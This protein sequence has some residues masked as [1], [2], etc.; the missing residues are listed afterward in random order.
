MPV[1]LHF[2]IGIGRN[3]E[4]E[5]HVQARQI[6]R[7]RGPDRVFYRPLPPTYKLDV[8][9]FGHAGGTIHRNIDPGAFI[10]PHVGLHGEV[11]ERAVQLRFAR[12]HGLPV[13][14]VAVFVFRRGVQDFEPSQV[15]VEIQLEILEI[16]VIHAAPNHGGVTVGV[17]QN[18]ATGDD[19]VFAEVDFVVE[20]QVRF[21]VIEGSAALHHIDGTTQQRCFWRTPNID[22]TQQRTPK[23]RENIFGERGYQ[24]QFGVVE[25]RLQRQRIGR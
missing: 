25:H 2:A 7:G 9:L 22:L 5:I 12:H 16:V 14:H 8:V 6:D 23:I 4:F 20:K 15:G 13:E 19:L 18:H 11:V 10:T 1:K 21:Q 3:V 24:P 17:A